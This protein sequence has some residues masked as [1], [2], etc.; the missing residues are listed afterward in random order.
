MKNDAYG[1]SAVAD[2]PRSE[3]RT[4]EIDPQE[5]M[6]KMEEAGTPG[7]AHQ[8]LE[9]LVG[10]W[11]AEVKCWHE[12]NGQPQVSHGTAEAKWTLNGRFLEEKFQGEMMG[13]PFRD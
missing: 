3:A 6:R 7:A 13:K 10:N 11:Q 8:A 12:P 4:P 1:T 9:A 5:M 2:R